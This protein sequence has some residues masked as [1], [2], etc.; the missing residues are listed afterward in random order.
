MACTVIPLPFIN[1]E[2]LEKHLR[3][4][5]TLFVLTES[6]SRTGVL[7]FYNET[8]NSYV[9]LLERVYPY[10]KVCVIIPGSMS[11]QDL[12]STFACSTGSWTEQMFFYSKVDSEGKKYFVDTPRSIDELLAF[13]PENIQSDKAAVNLVVRRTENICSVYLCPLP[14]V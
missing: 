1:E 10:K 2:D 5:L 12:I 7:V 9:A 8:S 13:T 3:R 14:A 11:V 6:D 4:I